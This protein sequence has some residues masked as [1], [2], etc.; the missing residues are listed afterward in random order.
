MREVYAVYLALF[1]QSFLRFC[2][3]KNEGDHVGRLVRMQSN[4][5]VSALCGIAW[6]PRCVRRLVA[7]SVID[8]G[9]AAVAVLCCVLCCQ[10]A[11]SIAPNRVL[12]A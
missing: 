9:S 10:L 5:L 12:L 7:G 1:S 8:G 3:R 2:G 6:C 11:P 4:R